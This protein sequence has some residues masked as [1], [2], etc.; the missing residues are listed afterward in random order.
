[1]PPTHLAL[2]T[3]PNLPFRPSN[4]VLYSSIFKIQP[5]K[6]YHTLLKLCPCLAYTLFYMLIS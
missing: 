5:S 2:C 1:M 6:Y 3:S 4:L